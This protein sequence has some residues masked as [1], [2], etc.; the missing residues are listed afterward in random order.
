MIDASESQTYNLNHEVK[1][2]PEDRLD[3]TSENSSSEVDALVSKL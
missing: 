3:S 2:E 1:I